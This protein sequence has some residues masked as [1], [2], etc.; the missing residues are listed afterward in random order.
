LDTFEK[1]YFNTKPKKY[2]SNEDL[3][4]Y[5]GCILQ[6]LAALRSI[7]INFKNLRYVRLHALTTSSHNVLMDAVNT[8]KNSPLVPRLT[9]IED[10]FLGITPH[11]E[12]QIKSY[13]GVRTLI[14]H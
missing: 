14:I 6:A 8:S 2:P 7:G 13:S 12:V 3:I 11:Y 1:K 4:H 10:V 9:D 5:A